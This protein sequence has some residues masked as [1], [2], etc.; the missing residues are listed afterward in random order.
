MAR[1][2]RQTLLKADKMIERHPFKPFVPQNSRI[3][4]L[5]S[6][7]GKESTQLKRD[8]DWFYGASRNQFWRI[9]EII[10]GRDLSRKEDKQQLFNENKIAITDIVLSCVRRDNK[11]SDDNLI[12]KEYNQKAIKEIIAANQVGKILFTSKGVQKEFLKHFGK[13]EKIEL[14]ALPS[15]SPVYGRLSVQDKALVYKEHLETVW[16]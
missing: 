14:F 11:N 6:F 12:D 1:T 13:P 7:P 2:A 4:I 10:F 15:P 8:N 5:G 16:I 9:L 3:L